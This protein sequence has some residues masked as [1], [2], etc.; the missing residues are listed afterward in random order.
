[1]AGSRWRSA[2]IAVVGAL[3]LVRIAS[4]GDFN[5]PAGRLGEVAAALGLQAGATITVTE[6]DVADQHSPGVSGSLSLH[7]AL[8][9]ALR[10]I[11]A[12]ALFY[13]GMTVR[14]VRKAP[15]RTLRVA[16]PAQAPSSTEEPVE[17]VVMASKQQMS[18]QTYPGSAKVLELDRDWTADHAAAGTAAITEL[19]PVLTSTNLGPGRDKLFIRGLADSS[20]N[21]PTQATTGEYLG[22]VRLNYNAPDPDLNLYDMQRIEVLVGPEGTLYGAG[23][24]GGVVRL[25]PNA[26][27]P[28]EVAVATSAGISATES[29]GI[30]RDGAALFNIP[31]FGTHAAIRLVAYGTRDAGY[32]DDLG[33]SQHDVNSIAS[34]G[35]RFTLRVQDLERW[36]L[37]FGVVLQNLDNADA[38]YA[39]RDAPPLTRGSAIAQPFHSN[40]LLAYI[41][42]RQALDD[43]DLVS[44]TSAVW[45]SLKT[46]YDATGY[47]GTTTPARFEEDNDITLISHETRMASRSTTVPWVVGFTTLFS[48]NIL[49]RT[50]GPLAA[51]VQIAGVANVQAE[52][53]LFGQI[54]HPLTRTLTGT[55][56]ERLTLANSTG[57]PISPR[58]TESQLVSHGSMSACNTLGLDW[59]PE[60]VFS[61]FFHYQQGYRPG[62]LAVAASGNTIESQKFAGDDLNMDEIGIRSGRE[63]YDPFW[64]RAAVFAADWNH[65]QADLIDSAGLPYT[66]NI[67]RGRIYG[68]DGDVSWR[69]W[70]TLTL[71]ADAFVNDS[72]LVAPALQFASSGAQTLPNVARTGG[73]LA[74]QWHQTLGLGQMSVETSIRY[75]GKS[76]LGVGQLL[77][78]PQGNYFVT[79]A[80]LRFDVGKFTVSLTLNNIGNIRANTFAFGNP[81]TVEQHDQMTPLQPRTIRLGTTLRF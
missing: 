4:A 66:T 16:E 61:A 62:G 13:D 50:L 56:G 25:V 45:Q 23:S 7:D 47:N 76:M 80:D 44:T 70:S 34:Y 54:S 14:I 36:T 53:A 9:R 65:M 1:M 55:I 38:Q 60:G 35:Q 64:V 2:G 5:I 30:S 78:I 41:E 26:P 69:P 79:D 51:P 6:P 57:L 58:I 11:D 8:D 24:L 75:V 81:F 18:L 72:R 71:S 68:V 27:D 37:D 22:N 67:G 32:I 3:G 31:L 42:A 48:T 49:S 73:R 40:Y 59:H 43:A 77:D 15:S 20:F 33:R 10:G 63:E 19:L 39:L 46:V 21:G 52:A 12:E 17:V 29:G 74:S 28:E